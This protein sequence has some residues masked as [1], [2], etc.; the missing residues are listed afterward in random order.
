MH[1]FGGVER[2][3]QAGSRARINMA[4]RSTLNRPRVLRFVVL[5]DHVS[6]AEQGVNL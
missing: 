4:D 6:T 1:D 2:R 5:K 3:T